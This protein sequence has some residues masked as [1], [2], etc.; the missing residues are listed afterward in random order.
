MSRVVKR[1][2]TA[3]STALVSSRTSC[4][5]TSRRELV[6]RRRD[7]GAGLLLLQR[8]LNLSRCVSCRCSARSG[9]LRNS[10]Q[11]TTPPP[12]A[13]DRLCAS[14]VHMARAA[15][16]ERALLGPWGATQFARMVPPRRKRSSREGRDAGSAA[17]GVALRRAVSRDP[18]AGVRCLREGPWEAH[19]ASVARS[20]GSTDGARRPARADHR[21]GGRHHLAHGRAGACRR[22]RLASR[23]SR[24]A[25]HRRRAGP[26]RCRGDGDDGRRGANAVARLEGGRNAR[27]STDQGR[28]DEGSGP[29][30]AS[31]HPAA[32]LRQQ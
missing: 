4:S 24:T 18:A 5:R 3:L 19:E 17:V 13:D 6:A 9:P 10:G 27:L 20:S 28:R 25:S 31:R 16:G 23:V 7:Q 1:R 14:C 21:P 32:A 11:R 26:S 2:S 22:H 8:R 30:A 12:R 15:R 29:Y